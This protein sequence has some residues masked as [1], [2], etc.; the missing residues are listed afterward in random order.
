[1]SRAEVRRNINMLRIEMERF[2]RE[3]SIDCNNHE[4][5]VKLPAREQGSR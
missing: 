2:E 5:T 3:N 1:M 4:Q